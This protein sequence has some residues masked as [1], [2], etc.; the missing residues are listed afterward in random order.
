M[1]IE[2]SHFRI[3]DAVHK[4]PDTINPLKNHNMKISTTITLSSQEFLPD[5][6]PSL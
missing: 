1:F 2:N 4:F 3:F 6:F 5:M